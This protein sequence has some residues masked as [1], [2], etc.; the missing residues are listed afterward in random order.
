MNR[1][2]RLLHIAARIICRPPPSQPIKEVLFALHW[3][4]MKQRIEYK[5]L[6]HCYKSLNGAGPSYL[7]NLLKPVVADRDLRSTTKNFLVVPKTSTKFG[8]RSFCCSAPVLWNSLPEE[9]KNI[10]KLD[11]FKRNL[12]THL[13]R[14][15]YHDL[16]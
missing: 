4:P 12:K 6:L 1:L 13:F 16:C 7:K 8:D 11:T 2:Q 10:S 14:K 5:V 3:L 15:V 9:L